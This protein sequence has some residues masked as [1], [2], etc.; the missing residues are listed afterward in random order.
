MSCTCCAVGLIPPFPTHEQGQPMG[1]GTTQ[2]SGR[3]A[4]GLQSLKIF[5]WKFGWRDRGCQPFGYPYCR[6]ARTDPSAASLISFGYLRRFRAHA[7][8]TKE[9]EIFSLGGSRI[10]FVD[11][12]CPAYL[13]LIV[14]TIIPSLCPQPANTQSSLRP[15]RGTPGQSSCTKRIWTRSCRCQAIRPSAY[16]ARTP[17]SSTSASTSKRTSPSTSCLTTA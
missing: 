4:D 7:S 6:A 17:T 13:T 16:P 15:I 9:C 1:R 12:N 5:C 3:C 14:V 11:S 8:A 10:W 2:P